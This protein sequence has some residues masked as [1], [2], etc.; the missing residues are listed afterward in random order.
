ME[1]SHFAIF[2]LVMFRGLNCIIA[3]LKREIKQKWYFF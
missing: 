1:D 3:L 2:K